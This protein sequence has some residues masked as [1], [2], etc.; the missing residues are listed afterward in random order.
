MRGEEGAAVPCVGCTGVLYGIIIGISWVAFDLMT[1][2]HSNGPSALRVD[3][4]V[5]WEIT[6]THRN[7]AGEQSHAY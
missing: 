4:M 7:P 1:P 3:F 5:S 2:V 6:F